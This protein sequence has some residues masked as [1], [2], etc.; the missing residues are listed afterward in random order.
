[1]GAGCNGVGLV[2][3][4]QE[5]WAILQR[6]STG[7]P[8]RHRLIMFSHIGA[9]ADRRLISQELHDH[10]LLSPYAAMPAETQSLII[11]RP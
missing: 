10:L 11:A 7:L 8:K 6:G 2:I 3:I 4:P 5:E 9:Y 1:M